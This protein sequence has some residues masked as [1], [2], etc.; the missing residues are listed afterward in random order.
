MER[1]GARGSE[2]GEQRAR[3]QLLTQSFANQATWAS[4][5]GLPL[6]QPPKEA[7]GWGYKKGCDEE[8]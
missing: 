7:L 5:L 8:R 3:Q 6:A 2:Q 4:A 1:M